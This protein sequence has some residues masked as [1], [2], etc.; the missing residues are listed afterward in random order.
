[1]FHFPAYYS[2]NHEPQTFELHLSV[3]KK[4]SGFDLVMGDKAAQAFSRYGIGYRYLIYRTEHGA[5]I[6]IHAVIPNGIIPSYNSVRFFDLS[7]A[8]NCEYLE[9]LSKQHKIKLMVIN[10]CRQKCYP[11]SLN[12]GVHHQQ[13]LARFIQEC[14]THNSTL[15][16]IDY[17]KAMEIIDNGIDG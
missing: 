17:E 7:D 15:T 13:I 8:D 3:S 12:H 11:T 2:N 1:M 16:S 6:G 4:K 9:N 14:L 5:I 10:L